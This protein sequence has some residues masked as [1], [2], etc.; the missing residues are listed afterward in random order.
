MVCYRKYTD[1]A[2]V[3][4]AISDIANKDSAD[5]DSANVDKTGGVVVSKYI[6]L[7]GWYQ[8]FKFVISPNES[9]FPLR[10]IITQ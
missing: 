2:I 10:F 5:M 8:L 9:Q 1:N 4:N 6:A 3:N 7:I